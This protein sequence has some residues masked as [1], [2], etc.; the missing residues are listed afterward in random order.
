MSFL[1]PVTSPKATILCGLTVVAA[2]ALGSLPRIETAMAEGNHNR[3]AAQR[4]QIC[5]ILPAS[6]KIELGAYYF[7]PTTPTPDGGMTGSLLNEGEYICDRYGTTARIERGGY[8]Q[9]LAVSNDVSAI[10]KTL[11]ER[12]KDSSNPDSSEQTQVKRAVNMGVHRER[13]RP[14]ENKPAEPNFFNLN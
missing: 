12:L 1:N 10:N 8:A 9:F 6:E 11:Q 5:R 13:P 7:Q 14:Q 2:G 3:I 4:S